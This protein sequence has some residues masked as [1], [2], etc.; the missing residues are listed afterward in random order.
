MWNRKLKIL[1]DHGPTACWGRRVELCYAGFVWEIYT[2]SYCAPCAP[3]STVSTGTAR[4]ECK[5]EQ[6]LFSLLSVTRVHVSLITCLTTEIGISERFNESQ[7]ACMLFCMKSLSENTL[8]A[9]L[10]TFGFL[11][12]SGVRVT[13]PMRVKVESPSIWTSAPPSSP[14]NDRGIMGKYFENEWCG[15]PHTQK[16]RI[17]AHI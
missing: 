3:F 11:Q 6:Y 4:D 16:K 14:W 9:A 2:G 7:F 12:S 1:T 17:R 10:G 8:T 15:L 13:K 5:Q